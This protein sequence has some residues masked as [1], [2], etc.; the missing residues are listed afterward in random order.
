MSARL[1]VRGLSIGIANR[2]LCDDLSWEVDGG[3]CCVIVGPN[4]AGKTTLVRTLAGLNPCRAGSIAY[5]GDDIAHLSAR[6]A[7]Q[8]RAWLPQVDHDAFPATVL[9]TVLVGRHPHLSRWSWESAADIDRA[10]RAL[11][12][13]GLAGL[14]T[15]EVASLSGGERRRV[16]LAAI[17]AQEAPLLLLDEPTAHLD[18]KHQVQMLDLFT[19]RARER[20][21]ALVIVLHDLH[22]ALRYADAA[23]AIANGRA[24]AGAASEILTREA[25]SALFAHPLVEAGDGNLRTLLPA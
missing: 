11:A 12:E 3:Q 20:G 17:V 14:E 19:A 13:V 8:R 4:G 1:S 24:S 15:R 10:R 9:E 7:A 16:A 21:Q 6:V 2:T 18:L 22:L 25:L 5:D 23:I